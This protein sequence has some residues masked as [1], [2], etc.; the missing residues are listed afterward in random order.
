MPIKKQPPK[1]CAIPGCPKPL[2]GLGYCDMHYSRFKNNG[3]PLVVQHTQELHGLS[4]TPE[5]GIWRGMKARC[6]NPNGHDY[7]RYGGRGI[8]VCDQWHNSFSAFYADMGP[9]PTPE[10]S[11]ERINNAGDYEPGN[12]K[13]ATINEQGCNKRNNRRLELNGKSL[14]VSQWCRLLGFSETVITM[15]LK[16]GWSVEQALTRPLRKP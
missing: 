4:K 6:H 14:T 8:K 1:P 3:D 5:H 16:R 2:Q 9:R 7:E 10:H 15:R 11:I 13:W 12:C